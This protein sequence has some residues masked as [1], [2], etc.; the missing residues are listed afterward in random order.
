[1][2]LTSA[3]S[4]VGWSQTWPAGGGPPP[5][6]VVLLGAGRRVE[7]DDVADVGIAEAR[8]DPVDE[9]A[10]ADLERRHHRL[11]RDPVG[12]D[13]E[14]LDAEREAERHDHDHDQLEQRAGR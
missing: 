13:E 1:M 3:F 12:L 2:K 5:H 7:D 14:G 8:A 6:G 11:R 4:G 10:L 9:H